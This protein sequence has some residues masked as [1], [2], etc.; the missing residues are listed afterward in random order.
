MRCL[1]ICSGVA[2]L[3]LLFAPNHGA[4][5]G[6]T[7]LEYP[8]ARFFDAEND[9]KRLIIMV[10]GLNGQVSWD[11]F[12]GLL[13][14]D[15]SFDVYDVLTYFTPES[16]DIESHVD[17]IATLARGYPSHEYKVFVGHSIG[18]III[19]RYTLRALE[20]GVSSGA[21]ALPVPVT[22]L[23]YGTPLNTD[24]FS[25]SLFKRAG[26]RIFWP[27]VSPLRKEV[28][29]IDRLTQINGQWRDA[30]ADDRIQHISVFGIEDR[31]ART[32]LEEQ[33]QVTV[34]I[35]G[36]HLGILASDRTDDCPFLILR[37]VIQGRVADLPNL[38]CIIG[39]YTAP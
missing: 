36:D 19:K 18:G 39:S 1:P 34:F 28:F 22:V 32:D 10:A 11:D 29:N 13:A 23:T 2:A 6:R 33:S 30:V 27:L 37:T 35:E 15:A 16:E 17:R 8:D 20:Q 26:A 9:D 14:D 7:V 24:K 25:I 12:V 31:I 3:A 38:A 4:A 21:A 5:A